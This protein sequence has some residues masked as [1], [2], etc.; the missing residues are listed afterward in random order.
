MCTKPFSRTKDKEKLLL[1]GKS[2]GSLLAGLPLEI[3]SQSQYES[4]FLQQFILR[5]VNN[6]AQLISTYLASSEVLLMSKVLAR[7]TRVNFHMACFPFFLQADHI[8]QNPLIG[9]FPK[10]LE[11]VGIDNTQGKYYR[12]V[13][14]AAHPYASYLTHETGYNHFNSVA[15][16][17]PNCYYIFNIIFY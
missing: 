6:M 8:Q 2:R 17:S 7:I 15:F 3:L 1:V 11:N 16:I 13:P 14:L 10:S 9:D 12:N 5:S 4:H